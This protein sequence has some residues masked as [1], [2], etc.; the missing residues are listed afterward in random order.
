MNMIDK[1]MV[2]GGCLSRVGGRAIAITAIYDM[3]CEH[4][5]AA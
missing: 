5:E 3:A 2:F 1:E 4:Q